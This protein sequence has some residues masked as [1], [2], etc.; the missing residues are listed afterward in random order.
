MNEVQFH[1]MQES[2]E[3]GGWLLETIAHSL[4]ITCHK[5]QKIRTSTLQYRR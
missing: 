5:R 3:I 2:A 1:R 4:G